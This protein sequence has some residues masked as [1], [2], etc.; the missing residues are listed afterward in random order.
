VLG[1]FYRLL[2]GKSVK[3]IN[4]FFVKHFDATKKEL[5]VKEWSLKF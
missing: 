1:Q 5:K 3:H 4:H 2:G